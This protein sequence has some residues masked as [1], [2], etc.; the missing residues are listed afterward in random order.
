MVKLY[1]IKILILSIIGR[2]VLQLL[3]FLNKIQ[4]KGEKNLS[5]IVD[6]KCPI[7]VCVWHG[8]LLFPSWYLR[9]KIKGAYAIAGRHNDAEIMARILTSWGYGLIRGSTGKGGNLVVEKMESVF[10]KGGIIC[11][12]N[13]GPKGPAQIAKPGSVLIA[14][15]Q[16]VKIITI[17]GSASKYWTINSWDK[18]IL[19]K[20]FGKI[21]III[22]SPVQFSNQQKDL[23][24]DIND[25]SNFITQFQDE[26]D[27]MI[28]TYCQ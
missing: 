24:S 18:F 27:L 1:K 19:P 12:T 14:I 2:W 28:N 16:N 13:D 17:T 6:L 11:V 3:F 8:R 21:Q 25:L 15:K 5:D 9:S 22:S 10:K 23:N 26:A 4:I 20:P 7:M